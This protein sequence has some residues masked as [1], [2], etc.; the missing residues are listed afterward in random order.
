VYGAAIMNPVHVGL[1]QNLL[2]ATAMVGVTVL[3]HFWGLILLLRIMGHTGPRLRADRSH[4]GQAMLVLVV[5]FGIFA[6]H[7]LE[8]WLYAML[9][10]ALGALPTLEPALYFSTVTFVALGYGDVVL[11]VT[12][13]MLSAIEAANGVILI[14]WSTAFLFSVTGRLRLL[15][16]N[17]LEP[18]KARTAPPAEDATAD[19]PGD[20]ET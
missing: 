2:L 18:R 6:L 15:E 12:W 1:L 7:T 4:A 14:A 10:L 3:I 13:R 17:W 20:V 19:G 5:V 8:I 9:Y 11:P 16:H